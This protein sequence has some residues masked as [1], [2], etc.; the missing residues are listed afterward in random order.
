MQVKKQ[1]LELDM[2]QWTGSKLENE[3]IKAVYCHSA[4]LTSMQNTSCEMPGGMNHKLKSRLTGINNLRYVDNTTLMAENEEELKRLLMKVKEESENAGLKLS[5]QQTK[6]MTFSS[7]TS[8]QTDGKT[9]ET[10]PDWA[11]NHCGW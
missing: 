9:M 5:I 7:I 2:E 10:V 11:P 6:F 4:Y 3:Y 8:W 1:P